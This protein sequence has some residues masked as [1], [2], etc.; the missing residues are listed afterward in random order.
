MV[1]VYKITNPKGKI[2]IGQSINIKK[3][4]E[5]Y[6]KINCKNQTKLYYSLKKYGWDNHIKEI[7]E[8]CFENELLER[9]TYWKN[10]YK[11]LEIPSL[12][13]RID[14]R[15]GKMSQEMKNKISQSSKGISRNKGIPKSESH[16]INMGKSRIGKKHS[17]IHIENMRKGMLGKN[18]TSILCINDNKIFKSIKEA[19][20]YY[21]ILPSSIDNILSGRAK[22]TRNKLEFKYL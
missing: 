6:E 4:W 18:T 10:Y 5:S 3:R 21:N 16:K 19:S 12:C 9:E 20:E 15:G 7:I 22:M 14:G 17:V 8:E 2:Y 13:C 1:G 11:V